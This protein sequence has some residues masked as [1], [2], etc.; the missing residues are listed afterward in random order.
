MNGLKTKIIRQKFDF[1]GPT[2]RQK[3][4]TKYLSKTIRES[5]GMIIEEVL[6]VGPKHISNTSYTSR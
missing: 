2:E 5:L 6:K 4:E 3:K 1:L